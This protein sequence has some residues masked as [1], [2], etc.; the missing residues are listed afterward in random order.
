MLKQNKTEQTNKKP[1]RAADV[2]KGGV[3]KRG[4][5]IKDKK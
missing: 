2:S 3:H 4:K 5:S 1:K